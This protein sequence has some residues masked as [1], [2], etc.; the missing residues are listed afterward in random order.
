MSNVRAGVSAECPRKRPTLS[1]E[2]RARRVGVAV[3]N[4]REARQRRE[5]MYRG[6]KER[7]QSELGPGSSPMRAT[8]IEV[9]CS[10]YVEMS[11]LTRKFLQCQATNDEMDR[12]SRCRAQLANVLKA[13]FD[14]GG[15]H[16][17]NETLDKIIAEHAE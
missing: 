14:A 2:E 9:A 13:L 17:A 15:N 11:A 6:Y 3:R 7:L 8:M 10:S 1:P 5:E 16:G 12:L 4:N